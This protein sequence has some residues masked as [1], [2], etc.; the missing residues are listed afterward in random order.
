MKV[1][2]YRKFNSPAPTKELD[3]FKVLESIQDGTYKE[4]ISNV[5][6]Y[7]NDKVKRDAEKKKLPLVS[8]CGTFSTRGNNNLIKHS[9]LACLDFDHVLN[10]IE[11]KAKISKDK[12]TLACFV[13]PSGDGVKVLVKIPK[14]GTDSDYKTFYSEL[15]KHYD[16]YGETDPST[17]DI[18]RATYLTHDSEMYINSA[19]EM[20]TDRFVPKEII[21][22][23]IN[24][25]IE[26]MDEISKRI[27]TWF[28]KQWTTGENR[29]NNLFILCAAFNDYGVDINTAKGYCY[30]YSSK[31]F[32]EREIDSLI[33]SA[34]KNTTNFGSKSFEDGKKKNEIKRMAATGSTKEQFKAK[35][36]DN[37]KLLAEFNEIVDKQG[38]C[39]FWYLDEK[40]QC[41]LSFL[42]F[43][44]WLK[45]VGV[46]KYYPYNENGDFEFIIKDDN[47]IDW[48]DS[49]RI[50]DMVKRSLVDLGE[51]E[52]WE[53]MAKNTNYF[54]R[55]TLSMLDT[56]KVEPKRD[57]KN[58][59]FLY[60]KN[61]AIETTKEGSKLIPYDEI[62]DVIWRNQVIDRDIDINSESEGE[63]KT[64]IWKLAS[65]DKKRYYTLKS[66]LGYLL[67]SYQNEAKPKAII[68]NDEMISDD[69]PNGGSGKGLI[70]KAI[71]KIK[72]V[73][74][75]D[76][77]SF[78][79]KD[80]FAYQNVTKDTQ[81]F[82]MDDVDKNFKFESLFSIV[83]EGMTINPKNQKAF[84]IPFKESPK[85]S[86]T[87]N[88]TV[89]GD[90]AS[91]YR[92]IFEVEIAN[93]FND[94]HAPEDE[95]GHQ[96]FSEWSI[97][98][99]A[100]FDNFMIRCI[101]FYLGNGLVESNKVNLELRKLKGSA[102][103]EF[104]EWMDIQDFSDSVSRKDLR[105]NFVK[106]YPMQ[107]KY[108]TAQ[109]F[110]KKVKDYCKYH[111]YEFEEK[112]YNGVWQF[113]ITKP[114][115][116]LPF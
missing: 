35:F 66:V 75:Q 74:I 79:P 94:S 68:F 55:D 88:Y 37:E 5:R 93:Y 33:N 78:D 10:V 83:T 47:F 71:D 25:C 21:V 112:Q 44:N 56:I 64:F 59:S 48:I 32:S 53:M 9:G 42:R 15:A 26:D 104:I 52:A 89:N 16:Q 38:E 109:R 31:D 12:Y 98:E 34:Y 63:F 29:N 24:V 65:E 22:K 54:K 99:W 70:H 7:I 105:D 4:L 90:G 102:G 36:G 58:E 6:L 62:D 81:I 108:N 41:K 103:Q 114:V 95:F 46:S 3:V 87:T 50:K 40:G 116:P 39:E 101:Q 45:S 72:N 18:S 111:K 115:E 84:K 2:L 73:E 17:K 30:Q 100:K 85:L 110:N 61:G 86:I 82:L 23:P 28:K 14:V 43:D 106:E 13:S 96:F 11:T 67:H 19:S 107:A 20:F 97:E 51:F 57:T 91:H 60:Y 80:K 76:G 92:R 8:F 77:K 69:I 1:S 49:A 113:H 27:I